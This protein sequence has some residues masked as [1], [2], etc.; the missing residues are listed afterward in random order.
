MELCSLISQDSVRLAVLMDAAF[1]QVD[2]VFTGW[3]VVDLA[4]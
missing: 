3:I 4:A 2:S 1:R